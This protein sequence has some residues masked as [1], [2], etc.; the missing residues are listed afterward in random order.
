MTEPQSDPPEPTSAPPDSKLTIF[1][2]YVR[3]DEVVTTAMSNALQG[4]FGTDITVFMDKVSIQQGD[5]IRQVIEANLAKSDV[6]V[7]VST[8]TER[9]SHDWAGF[10]LGYFAA[11][12]TEPKPN[13]PL[14]GRIVTLAAPGKDPRPNS[15]YLYIPLEV[16]PLL[17]ASSE[18]EFSKRV[19]DIPDDDPLLLWF[20]VLY[21]AIYG[22][23]PL[24][25]KADRDRYRENIRELK[26]RIFAEF[27]RRPKAVMR[28]QKRI[29]VRHKLDATST[30]FDPEA[31][32]I[33]FH[34]GAASVFGIPDALGDSAMSWRHFCQS[35]SA[36][37]HGAFWTLTL[38]ELLQSVALRGIGDT[39]RTVVASQSEAQ[40]YR[41]VLGTLTTFYD[42]WVESDVDV[43]EVYRRAD[44]GNP[45]TTL[46]L[47]GLQLVC[48]FRF[49]FLED[50][51]EFHH[52]N[53]A[54]LA[55]PQLAER[56][57]QIARE[58]EI[59]KADSLEACLDKPADWRPYLTVQ[60]LEAM[61]R[62]WL[63][64][65]A[66]LTTR[67]KDAIQAASEPAQLEARSL[68]ADV[69]KRMA[70]EVR[71]H[72]SAMLLALS[73]ALGQIA[74]EGQSEDPPAPEA[75]PTLGVKT[76]GH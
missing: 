66:A 32:T 37:P 47:K 30:E 61:A 34:G 36:H 10:E 50:Q 56:A 60:Q 73:A 65:E 12:H 26:C 51:S 58:L 6:L 28:P 4:A 67:C 16:A 8:G 14:W 74:N 23:S 17:L 44:F 24:N 18:T 22:V 38:M 62:T 31:T 71:P 39:N 55:L 25:R 13:R 57:R 46:L 40:L 19:Q 7:I 70:S 20:G 64:L 2:S 49:L 75:P 21:E 27:K 52:L 9:P 53:I 76:A 29:V 45:K 43:I 69:L 15:G 54:V 42:G 3:E 33:T 11:K 1:I 72:N 59:L 35:V 68:L 41:L 48:R 5:N 63:P